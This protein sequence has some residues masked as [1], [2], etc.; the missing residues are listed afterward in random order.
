M[1]P[2][3][4]KSATTL[5]IVGALRPEARTR[6][7]LEQ[8][9]PSR[10]SLRTR[11]ALVWRKSEGLPTEMGSLFKKTSFKS[12]NLMGPNFY[13]TRNKGACARKSKDSN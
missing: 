13:T 6:S 12:P 5:V 10:R 2:A 1:R 11:S 3:E 8:D 4:S 7:A 9:P